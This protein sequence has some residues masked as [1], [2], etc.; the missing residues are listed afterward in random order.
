L[1]EVGFRSTAGSGF[2]ATT[3]ILAFLAGDKNAR[4]G[5][6]KKKKSGEFEHGLI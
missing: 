3:A 1:G 4:R 2:V 5:Q 6:S